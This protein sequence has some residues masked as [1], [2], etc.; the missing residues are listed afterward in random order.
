[1]GQ[2]VASLCEAYKDYFPIGAAV[3]YRS[4]RTHQ[5]LLLRHF[6]SL[7]P[8]NEMKFSS[9]H[10]AEDSYQFFFAD[11]IVDFAKSNGMLVRGHTLIW[12]QQTPEWVFIGPDGGPASRELLLARMKEHIEAVVSRYRGK[13]YCWDVVNEAVSDKGPEYLR[14]SKWLQ[15][16]GPDYIE[17]AFEYAHAADPDA[18]LFYNDYN[19]IAR[20]KRERIVQLVTELRQRGIPIHGVG[21]QGHWNIYR[22][23]LDEIREALDEYAGLGLTLQITE[24]DMSVFASGDDRTDLVEPTS[25]MMALQ[26]ERYEKL[27]ELFREYRGVISGVTLWG[28]ADDDT[29]LHNFP[30]KGRRD[31][32]LLFDSRHRPKQSF[33]RIV[34]FQATS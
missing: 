24:L 33:Y 19:E 30:V 2:Q 29:W 27:F 12:H 34:D 13:V 14:P 15:I 9:V 20:P 6:C 16:I 28:I 11:S 21:L 10:P 23:T 26:A 31:W 5:D 17:K 3:S 32:P 4:I 25:E 1:M 7:T 22:P 8:S 18:L